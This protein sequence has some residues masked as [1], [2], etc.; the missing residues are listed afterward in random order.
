MNRFKSDLPDDRDGAPGAEAPPD[1]EVIE[2]LLLGRPLPVPDAGFRERVVVAMEAAAV[3]RRLLLAGRARI[4]PAVESRRRILPEM[5]AAIAAAIAV[6]VV[7]WGGGSRAVITSEAAPRRVDEPA[8]VHHALALL[9][10]RRDLFA[11]VAG[12]GLRHPG[13]SLFR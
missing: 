10:A 7:P 2:A 1:G 3:E 4:A 6:S 9:D 8:D 11:A 12:T 13:E 5:V